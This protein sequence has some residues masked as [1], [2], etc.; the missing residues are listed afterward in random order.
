[1]V[2]VRGMRSS[3][4]GTCAAVCSVLSLCCAHMHRW[5]YTP[6]RWEVCGP[7]LLEEAVALVSTWMRNLR[8]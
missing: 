3:R 8:P 4:C 5:R 7:K 1:M 6:K 2:W